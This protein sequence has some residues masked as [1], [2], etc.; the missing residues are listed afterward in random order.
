MEKV[1]DAGAAKLGDG[2]LTYTAKNKQ[3]KFV[4]VALLGCTAIRGKLEDISILTVFS[5]NT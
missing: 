3:K 4:T 5:I 1:S 2:V